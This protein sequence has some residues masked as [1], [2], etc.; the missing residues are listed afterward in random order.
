MRIG[1]AGPRTAA[2]IQRPHPRRRA[3]PGRTA[4]RYRN[5]HGAQGCRRRA[6]PGVAPPARVPPTG[7]QRRAKGGERR[8]IELVDEQLRAADALEPVELGHLDSPGCGLEPLRQHCLLLLRVGPN[9]AARA[10]PREPVDRCVLRVD[11]PH[12]GRLAR[13]RGGHVRL[14]AL[15][16]RVLA[17]V[18]QRRAAHRHAS[19]H[20]G[21]SRARRMS[22]AAASPASRS[23]SESTSVVNGWRTILPSAS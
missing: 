16:R 18:E 7:L 14:E 19:S 22:P 11:R 21:P 2:L 4:A 6:G 17:E 5:R 3:G 20:V 9:G 1:G 12:A 13:V 23:A 8:R 10:V 15:D